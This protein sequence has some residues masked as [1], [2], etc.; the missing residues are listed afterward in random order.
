MWFDKYEYASFTNFY[1]C[2]K[3]LVP[4]KPRNVTAIP[5]GTRTAEVSWI[6]PLDENELNGD[7]NNLEFIIDF[8]GRVFT[9]TSTSFSASDLK[10]GSLNTISVSILTLLL[11]K[12]YYMPK[13]KFG[14]R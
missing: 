14:I 11:L 6:G 10:P 8:G 2:Y 1:F 13:S 9:T 3:F 7:I 4:E 12:A 5:S